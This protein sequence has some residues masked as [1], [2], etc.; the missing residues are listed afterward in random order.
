MVRILS[1]NVNGLRALLGK[2]NLR[3]FLESLGA[4]IVCMQETKATSE[5]RAVWCAIIGIL[6][7]ISGRPI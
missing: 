3:E 4:D 2:G 7:V 6:C 1:W 5:S